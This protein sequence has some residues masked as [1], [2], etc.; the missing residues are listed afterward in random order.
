MKTIWNPPTDCWVSR[1]QAGSVGG[2]GCSL[3]VKIVSR[4]ARTLPMARVA[5]NELILKT[6]TRNPFTAPISAP[7][8]TERTIDQAMPR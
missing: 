2:E 1:L 3:L 8:A 4:A 7:R 6:T 5:I